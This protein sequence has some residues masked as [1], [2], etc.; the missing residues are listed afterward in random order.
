ME[1][2]QSSK[3]N[4][5]KSEKIHLREYYLSLPERIAPKQRMLESIQDE[6]ERLTGVKPTITTVRNWVLYGLR[7]QKPLYTQAIVNVTK[8]KEEDLWGA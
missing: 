4:C 3:E 5:E 7:P 8:I 1:I 2:I 6:C